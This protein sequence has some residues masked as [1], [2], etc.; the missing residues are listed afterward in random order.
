MDDAKVKAFIEYAQEHSAMSRF[1][2]AYIQTEQQ[3]KAKSVKLA[4][5]SPANF[6]HVQSRSNI[7]YFTPSSEHWG[8]ST[9]MY[10]AVYDVVASI[11]DKFDP[12]SLIAIRNTGVDGVLSIFDYRFVEKLLA[13]KFDNDIARNASKALRETMVS[14]GYELGLDKQHPQ[15]D[16]SFYFKLG[17]MRRDMASYV[18]VYECVTGHRN[19]IS[20]VDGANG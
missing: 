8:N 16:R 5:L 13:K 12:L 17:E 4:E 20:T 19:I 3:D 9:R 10:G 11:S 7:G 1:F 18:D 6:E 2:N 15:V 14:F